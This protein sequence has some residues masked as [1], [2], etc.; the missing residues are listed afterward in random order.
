M[1]LH[2][3]TSDNQG[4]SNNTNK[5]CKLKDVPVHGDNLEGKQSNVIRLVFDNVDGFLIPN[6][7]NLRDQYKHNYKQV[8]LTNMFSRL[9]IDLFEAAETR[10]QFYLLPHEL[11]L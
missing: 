2:G 9:D 8:Y 7:Q 6:R 5:W 10:Q 4:K 11:S 3:D 1:N